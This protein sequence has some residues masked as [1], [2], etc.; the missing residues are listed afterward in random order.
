MSPKSPFHRPTRFEILY[1]QR[2]EKLLREYF[3]LPTFQTLGE[4]NARLVEYGQTKNFLESFATTL[5]QQM[6]TGIAANNARNWRQ[7]ASESLRGKQIYQML[8]SELRG[9]VGGRVDALVREN[10]K[11][12]SSVP[13]DVAQML[14][15]HIQEQ[16]A[17]GVR[18]E[19][20]IKQLAPKLKNFARYKIALIARTEVAKADT[21]ITRARAEDIGL[22]WYQWQ[23]S[24]DSRV[25][26]SH[27]KMDLV[28]INWND[29]PSPERLVGEKSQGHYHAGNIYNCRCVALPLVSLDE[30]QF[31]AKVYIGG[32][33][34]RL[35]RNQFALI[36]KVPL[37][38]VA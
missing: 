21:A 9:H 29:A 22:N 14:T 37:K 10:A 28:L 7:A 1:Q 17:A 36:S 15:K 2:I 38:I 20:I 25:R 35:T 13:Q 19:Q 30:I 24:E 12:I 16:Q 4:L 34:K 8:Q 6:I 26:V 11:L 23:T 3:N 27:R 32:Q 33:I 31:P 5:A 18:S